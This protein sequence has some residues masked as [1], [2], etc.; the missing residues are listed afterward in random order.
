MFLELQ[1]FP[2][3]LEGQSVYPDVARRMVASACDGFSIDPAI[4]ARGDDGKTLQGVVGDV[5]TGR[6]WGVPPRVTFGAG[7]GVVRVIGLGASGSA[8]VAAQAPLIA[9]ALGDHLRSECGVKFVRGEC[10]V[11]QSWPHLYR[12]Q[13][14]VISKKPRSFRRYEK[15]GAYTLESVRP[16]VMRAIVGGLVSQAQFL[17]DECPLESSREAQIGTDEMLGL[18]CLEGLIR[19]RRIR[20]GAD[21]FA[22]VI[23]RLLISLDLELKGLW[24]TGLLR[25]HGSGLLMSAEV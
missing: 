25:S 16:L 5:A 10:H 1:V 8:L 20:S 22:I 12:I 18:K 4:F 21:G 14:L 13:E 15:D 2:K 19:I 3:S 9:T 7:R 24:Y 6:G 11:E 17:D 23:Q